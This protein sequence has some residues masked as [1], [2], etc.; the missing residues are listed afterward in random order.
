MEVA[1]T[2]ICWVYKLERLW[3]IMRANG[4]D[5]IHLNDEKGSDSLYISEVAK[6]PSREEASLSLGKSTC[7]KILA[8][9]ILTK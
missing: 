6:H 1:S 2:V 9:Q 7:H 5:V 4:V 3:H 8:C